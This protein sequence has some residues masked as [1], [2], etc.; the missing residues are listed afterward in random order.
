MISK[1]MDAFH[2][3]QNERVVFE[4]L[5]YIGSTT[6]SDLARRSEL[7]RNTTRGL[8]DKLS[9]LG[10]VSKSTSGITQTYTLET[11]ENII[12]ALDLKK[13]ALIDELE[14]QKKAVSALDELAW[15][16][17]LGSKPKIT[18]H[19]GYKGLERVYE[20]SLT[21]KTGIIS[22][23]SFDANRDAMPRYFSKYYERRANK[24]IA[25]RSIHPATQ[26]AKNHLPLNK[27][28]LR[29]ALLV[30]EDKFRITPEIQVYNDKVSIVSWKEKIAVLLESEEIA[31]ALRSIF[32]LSWQGAKD[33]ANEK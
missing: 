14:E 7:P 30:P 20:D 27:K 13:N 16:S 25:I 23:A 5:S 19:E 10:L 4:Q 28:Q 6:A 33:Y 29:T 1:V 26:L 8:L 32:E 21:A 2:L 12:K 11:S 9:S 24:K 31:N 3:I 17:K 18:L 22:W 15:K